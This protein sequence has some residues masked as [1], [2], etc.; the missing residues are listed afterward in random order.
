[1]LLSFLFLHLE[2]E[3]LG[4]GQFLIVFLLF[5]FIGQILDVSDFL[6]LI[7]LARLLVKFGLEGCDLL[8]SG[9]K[10]RGTI[11]T[12]WVAGPEVHGLGSHWGW[13]L[14]LVIFQPFR[15]IH[16]TEDSAIVATEWIIALHAGKLI[17]FPQVTFLTFPSLPGPWRLNLLIGV[18]SADGLLCNWWERN[19]WIRPEPIVLYVAQQRLGGLLFD[20]SGYVLRR[21]LRL[22]S[23]QF[24]LVMVVTAIEWLQIIVHYRERRPLGVLTAIYPHRVNARRI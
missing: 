12:I 11:V 3:F 18:V 6:N 10:N 21:L 1:L 17:S 23:H 19:L 16:R 24:L 22:P 20:G 14:V 7:T 5:F 15:A 9:V 8:L 13:T 2:L 4:I